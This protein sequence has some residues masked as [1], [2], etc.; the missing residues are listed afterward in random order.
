MISPSVDLWCC[1]WSRHC[2]EEELW[3]PFALKRGFIMADK[4]E[5][6]VHMTTII[7]AGVIHPVVR[8]NRNGTQWRRYINNL[9]SLNAIPPFSP[10]IYKI[11]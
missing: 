9:K 3:H 8:T 10:N 6:Y 11:L 2:E 7:R 5:F 4:K 1:S